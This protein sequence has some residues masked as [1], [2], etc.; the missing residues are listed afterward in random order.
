MTHLVI[1]ESNS[2][3]Y[4]VRIEGE[5]AWLNLDQL[6]VLFGRDRSV[7]GKH[8]RKI[9]SEGELEKTSVWA[10]FAHTAEDGKTYQ[11]EHFN[12][13]VIIS[14]GYRVKSV[15]GTRFRQWVTSNQ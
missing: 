12:L 11:V 8:I 5:S 14:V 13:D 2:G 1:C 6:S 15:V 7:I 3:A 10:N 9:F 4:E